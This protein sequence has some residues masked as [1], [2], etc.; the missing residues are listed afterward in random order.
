MSKENRKR[1]YDSLVASGK[2]SQD[3]GSLVKEFGVKPT[4]TDYIPKEKVKTNVHRR[5]TSPRS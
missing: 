1:M 4:P 2:L 5:N 3:D